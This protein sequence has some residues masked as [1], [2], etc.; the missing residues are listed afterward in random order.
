MLTLFLARSAKDPSAPKELRVVV[1]D[2][3]SLNAAFVAVSAAKDSGFKKV[4]F[5]GTI[6][7]KGN[8]RA[9]AKDLPRH[10]LED[11]ETEKLY[12]VLLTNMLKC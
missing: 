7:P 3:A 8:V 11:F 6:P 4:K 1:R 12:Q 5:T 2:G 10:H 9:G